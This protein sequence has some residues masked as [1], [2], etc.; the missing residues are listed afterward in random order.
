M[1]EANNL[2]PVC[3]CVES[4][5]ASQ[6]FPGVQRSMAKAERV[7]VVGAGPVG[8]AAALAC[9]HSGYDVRIVDLELTPAKESRAVVVNARTL[10][11]LDH[12][13]VAADLL[14][15]G[16]LV[17]GV[18][19]VAEGDVVAT[20]DVT[21]IDHRFNFMLALPQSETEAILT[22]HLAADGIEVERGVRVLELFQDAVR[23]NVASRF[24]HERRE[25]MFDWV[26]GAD[27]AHSTVRKALA[28]D[29]VGGAYPF[30]W[31][32]ADVDIDGAV[33]MEWAELRLDP[34]R[35]VLFRI[36]VA[37]GRHRLISNAPDV[38][39]RAPRS[40]HLGALHW[41][42][43]FTVNHRHVP[44]QGY[45][46]VWLAGDAAHIH[47]PAGGR[48]MNLGIEDAISFPRFL[49][50]GRLDAWAR[51]RWRKGE[52]V[53]KE[54]DRLQRLATNDRSLVRRF[55]PRLAGLAL[56]IPRIQRRFATRNAGL[57]DLRP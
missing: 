47:S 46:R 52:T 5:T 38:L 45:G 2:K 4:G 8:L 33:S 23:V 25:E 34:G 40:W 57:F 44:K 51:W 31:S 50:A 55:G 36:P 13:G 27:G 30:T 12:F 11:L 6:F 22:D 1:R 42:S 19:V 32:L 49:K 41:S 14:D 9:H 48:G 39:E 24:E 20:L 18:H 26:L 56:K 15:A 7:L 28:L 53:L 16:V 54:S 35:P 21:T 29:F 10:D 17:H 3:D 37:P 43:E